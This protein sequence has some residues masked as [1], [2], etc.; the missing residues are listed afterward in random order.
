MSMFHERV[1]DQHRKVI[2][3]AILKQIKAD[4]AG[5]AI[6]KETVKKCI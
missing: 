6:N 2:T 4:R 3:E 5:D 1:F